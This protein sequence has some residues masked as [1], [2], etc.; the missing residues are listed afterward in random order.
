ME[1]ATPGQIKRFFE[2]FWEK[3]EKHKWNRRWFANL[4]A[5]GALSKLLD[6][7]NPEE[8]DLELLEKACGLPISNLEMETRVRYIEKEIGWNYIR[9]YPKSFGA[10]I[11]LR[12]FIEL[13]DVDFNDDGTV[14][15]G[16][17]EQ[18]DSKNAHGCRYIMKTITRESGVIPKSW[19]KYTLVFTGSRRQCTDS[20]CNGN[21]I[22]TILEY[23][24]ERWYE[25]VQ[26][27]SS[28]FPL[29]SRYVRV[30]TDPEG[31]VKNK[32][33]STGQLGSTFDGA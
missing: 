21:V 14:K 2:T 30:V 15:G 6:V 33:H 1:Q 3:Y 11:S 10:H 8:I 32:A 28:P 22:I 7:K 27:E 16:I 25:K 26:C 17:I 9:P 12:E 13:V 5:S 19:E 24:N 4:F 29:N 18:S 20:N 23:W 31:I